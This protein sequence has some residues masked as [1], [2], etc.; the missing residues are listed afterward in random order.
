MD[1][2][3]TVELPEGHIVI[4]HVPYVNEKKEAVY[5]SLISI[6]DLS[7]DNTITS[8]THVEYLAGSH[9]CDFSGI[10]LVNLVNG[11]IRYQYKVIEVFIS[12]FPKTT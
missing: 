5:G 8:S 3:Y 2:G 11:R 4:H 12:L 7:G 6:L 10:L 9:P 1:E